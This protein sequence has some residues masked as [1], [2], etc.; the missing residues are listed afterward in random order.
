MGLQTQRDLAHFAQERLPTPQIGHDCGR[1]G[2]RSLSPP[3][4]GEADRRKCLVELSDRPAM[5]DRNTGQQRPAVAAQSLELTRG[6]AEPELDAGLRDANAQRA[7]LH[8][9]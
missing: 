5:D 3:I 1:A 8:H 7:E 9:N 6:Q 2:A 4:Q